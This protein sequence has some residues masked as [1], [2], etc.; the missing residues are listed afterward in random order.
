MYEVIGNAT[1]D[2]VVVDKYSMSTGSGFVD[3]TVVES[4]LRLTSGSL[5]ALSPSGNDVIEGSALKASIDVM[6]GDKVSFDWLFTTDESLSG[7]F[8]A[9]NVR[10]FAFL[11]LN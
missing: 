3:A 11:A 7:L 8:P 2:L 4:F 6:V 9:A 10:D 1:Q 5:D